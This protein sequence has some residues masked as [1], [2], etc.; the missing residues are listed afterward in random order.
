MRQV[1]DRDRTR[2][3]ARG[4]NQIILVNRTMN[5]SQASPSPLKD[6]PLVSI[7]LFVFNEA[8]HVRQALESLLAQ[9]YPNFEVLIS[10][11]ASTDGTSELCQ[12]LADQDSRIDYRRLPENVGAGLNSIKV[13]DRARGKYFMWASGHDLWDTDLLSQCVQSLEQRPT[14]TIAYASSSWIDPN[15]Q[16]L[17]RHVSSYDT[18]GMHPLARFFT[19]FWGNMHPILGVIRLSALRELPG[20]PTCVGNDL[21]ILTEL[22]LKGEFLYCESRWRRRQPRP[23]EN[24]RERLRRYTH[25]TFKLTSS[26]FDRLFPL[27]RLPI[28]LLGVVARARLSLGERL[29]LYLALPA[30]FLAR[31]LAGRAQGNA[32]IHPTARSG[33]SR[34]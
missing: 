25:S 22:A 1:P 31:Y 12:E 8:T 30:C 19:V 14:A 3:P 20:I 7:G 13:L 32:P 26:R 15:D 5:C 24:H 33:A 10:D 21:L 28:G 23:A 4:I 6:Q 2:H 17:P 11:N 16:P 18:S 34:G 9:D 27:V 29:A